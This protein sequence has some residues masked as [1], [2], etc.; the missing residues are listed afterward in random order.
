MLTYYV[1]IYEILI[2]FSTFLPCIVKQKEQRA[3]S[4]HCTISG[5]E[6]VLECAED[7]NIPR[8][9]VILYHIVV[10]YCMEGIFTRYKCS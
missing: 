9:E 4:S 10:T 8:K 5:D 3:S 7:I 2:A 1:Y 6:M